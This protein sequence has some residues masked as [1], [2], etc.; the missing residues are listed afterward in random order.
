MKDGKSVAII[1]VNWNGKDIL[2]KCLDSIYEKTRYDNFE[3][4]VVDNGST[5][6]TA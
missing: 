6:G 2:K 3:V 5:D 1:I 4:F